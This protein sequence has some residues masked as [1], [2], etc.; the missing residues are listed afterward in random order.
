MTLRI[1]R[2]IQQAGL[3]SRRQAEE[4]IQAGRVTVNG[5][6]ASLGETADPDHDTILVDG[7]P[8]RLQP[9]WIYLALH[10][11]AGYT[12]S[13]ADRH[14]EHL[15]SE[16]IPAKYGR[17]FPVGRLD[18]DTS[19]LILLTNDGALAFQLLHPA[20][21][22][23]KVYEAWVKG[24]PRESHLERLRRGIR[25]AD[26]PAYPEDIRILRKE[27]D[28][29]LIRLTLREGKKREVRRIFET[30]GHPVLELK[31]IQFGNILLEGL[32]EGSIRPLTHHEIKELKQLVQKGQERSMTGES[33][34]RQNPSH[35]TRYR[36]RE[37]LSARTAG[38][39][40]RHPGG[41]SSR[42]HR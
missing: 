7:Q 26:G 12:T 18:R 38:H 17:V 28:R 15:I 14:A 37:T 32:T 25:L 4:W 35:R 29:T 20:Y 10:K 24:K 27:P 23:P 9:R 33:P 16:L 39:S 13:L 21:R 1:Q 42:S 22:I 6:V 2:I 34:G 11:P 31:R 19:G 3:A 8:I 40:V 36:G 41:N 5:H 30:I